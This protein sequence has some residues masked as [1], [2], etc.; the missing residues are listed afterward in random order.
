MH[1]QKTL[2]VGGTSGIS[3]GGDATSRV[4]LSHL[5][6]LKLADTRQRASELAQPE[7]AAHKARGTHSPRPC[8][9]IN[10]VTASSLRA[11]SM[12]RRTSIW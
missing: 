10:W 1:A 3:Q 7:D 11:G 6:S 2:D 4:L 12:A 8:W 9:E 5:Q